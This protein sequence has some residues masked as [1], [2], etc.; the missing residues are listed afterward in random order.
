MQMAAGNNITGVGSTTNAVTGE[1]KLSPMTLV[2]GVETPVTTAA[3]NPNV[4]A[5][6]A[7]VFVQV[8]FVCMAY[9]PIAAYL[10]EAFPARVRYTSMSLPYHIGNGVFGGLLPVIGLSLCA[11]TGSIYAGLAYP[12]IIALLTVVIGS[13]FLPETRTTRIWDE[14][15]DHPPAEDLIDLRDDEAE[16]PETA[17]TEG[18]APRVRPTAARQAAAGRQR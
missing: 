2:N 3:A 14:V 13:R 18:A 15:A 7:L 11:A 10:V 4:V 12:I 6:V 16:A 9:G 8:L 17:H 1:I 5:L